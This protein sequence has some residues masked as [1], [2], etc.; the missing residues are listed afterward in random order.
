MNR[1]LMKKAYAGKY[2]NPCVLTVPDFQEKVTH[3]YTNLQLK[4]AGLFKYV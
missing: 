3:T 1:L 2:F 4:S